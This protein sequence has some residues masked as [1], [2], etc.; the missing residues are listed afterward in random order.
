M[1]GEPPGLGKGVGANQ[2]VGA[3]A[4][5]EAHDIVCRLQVVPEAHIFV[6]EHIVPIADPPEDLQ[7]APGSQLWGM[8]QA[9]WGLGRM[10]QPRK[11]GLLALPGQGLE[12]LPHPA[13]LHRGEPSTA[14]EGTLV[15]GT[16]MQ[17]QQPQVVPAGAFGQAAEVVKEQALANVQADTWGDC[18]TATSSPASIHGNTFV[19]K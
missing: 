7:Q 8:V 2:E 15:A 12:G 3:G 6:V 4:G 19:K 11:C 1:G 10:C 9:A 17:L 18:T 14:E 16:T 13:L 5:D